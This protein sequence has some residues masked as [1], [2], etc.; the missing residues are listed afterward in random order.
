MIL[1]THTPHPWITLCS[2]SQTQPDLNL[3]SASLMR[4]NLYHHFSYRLLWLG[5]CLVCCISV[6]WALTMAP[7]ESRNISNKLFSA[8][9]TVELMIKKTLWLQILT[10]YQIQNLTLQ[11]NFSNS[12]N[13][14]SCRKLEM[15]RLFCKPSGS[16]TVLR[17]L[18]LLLAVSLP[19]AG[20]MIAWF[21]CMNFGGQ[22]AEI[23]FFFKKC[24]VAR[25][26]A[27]FNKKINLF[28]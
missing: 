17:L 13:K 14:L 12:F 15:K 24:S 19:R 11:I 2:T 16:V 18:L 21:K 20:K 5:Y 28:R 7:A 27:K 25:A 9:L 26:R 22:S 1:S 3:D 4:N 8:I 6:S 10:S 23:S